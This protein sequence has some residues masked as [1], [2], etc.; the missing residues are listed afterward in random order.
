MGFDVPS[1]KATI[2]SGGNT[3][4]NTTTLQTIGASVA[5]LLANPA[6]YKNKFL[7]ISDFF[8]TQNEILAIL[9][10][11][12]GSKFVVTE[13]DINK[14]KEDSDRGLAAGEWTLPNIYAAISGSIFGANSSTSWGE[15]DDTESL[16]LPKKDLTNEIKKVL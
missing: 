4:V 8:V 12:T 11:E 14:L 13:Q 6:P 9:E 3:K 10:A 5:A 15:D 1:K 2:Y 7:R 16:G